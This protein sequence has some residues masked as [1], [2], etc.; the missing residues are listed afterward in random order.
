MSRHSPGAGGASQ[1]GQQQMRPPGAVLPLTSTLVAVLDAVP[2]GASPAGRSKNGKSAW[3]GNPYSRRRRPHTASASWMEA[4]G[5]GITRH[6]CSCRVR[7]SPGPAKRGADH[8][9]GAF[10]WRIVQQSR[11][12]EDAWSCPSPL[13]A[14][15][16]CM[17]ASSSCCRSRRVSRRGI[18]AQSLPARGALADSRVQ[19]WS[20]G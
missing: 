10:D 15:L 20:S 5:A 2:P 18:S 13:A 7:S 3:P 11:F 16:T 19:S 8:K 6:V 17:P 4:P 1:T 12:L 14:P 9:S